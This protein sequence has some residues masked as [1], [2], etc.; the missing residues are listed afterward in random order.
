MVIYKVPRKLEV[1]WIEDIKAIVDT[2]QSYFVTQFEF[3]RAILEKGLGHA[4]AN[5][6]I[7]WIVDST[8]ASGAMPKFMIDFIDKKVFPE[9]SKN[10]IKYFIT[11][12]SGASVIARKTV[13]QFSAKTHH[14]GLILVELDN[15]E[16]A[17]IWLKNKQNE[18]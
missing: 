14:N 6:G 2:W 18:K 11:I 16:E 12:S 1:T 8:N 17:I 15:L 9:F 7:A 5:N 13:S 10:G 4:K 3:E